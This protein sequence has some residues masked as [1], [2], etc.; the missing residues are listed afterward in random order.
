M[1]IWSEDIEILLDALQQNCVYL[2][3]FHKKRYFHFK[4]IITY[5]RI[6]T[7]VI[8]SIASVAAVGLG[9]YL[10]QTNISG[11]TCLMSLCVSILNS[12]ELFLKINETT[13]LELET[14]KAYY[15][16]SANIHKVLHLERNNRKISGLDALEKYYR[17]YSELYESSALIINSYPDKFLHIP[18]RTKI[19]EVSDLSLSSLSSSSTKSDD[20]DSNP[21]NTNLEST[22]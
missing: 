11:I 4:N 19:K 14:S 21:L 3:K 6:P 9:N 18:K 13:I 17:D 12:I 2:N 1:E 10:N 15:H 22:L 16:L 8:S 7:I 5:F 20:E